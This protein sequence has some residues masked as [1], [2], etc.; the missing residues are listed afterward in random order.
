M[1]FFKYGVQVVERG[2]LWHPGG[3]SFLLSSGLRFV[4]ENNEVGRLFVL[5]R[6]YVYTQMHKHT[7]EV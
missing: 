4:Y 7:L 6:T 1:E 2:N 3:L 5:G